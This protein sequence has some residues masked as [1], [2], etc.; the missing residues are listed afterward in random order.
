MKYKVS[1][2]EFAALDEANKALYKATGED[3]TLSVDGMPEIEDVAGLK[4]TLLIC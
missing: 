2:E 4:K 3:Y 1:K